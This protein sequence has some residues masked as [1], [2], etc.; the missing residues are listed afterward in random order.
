MNYIS[1]LS[2]AG[3]DPSGGA[4]IQ[5]DLKTISALGCYAATAITAITVQNTKGVEAVHSVEEKLVEQQI[6]AVMDDIHP[7]VVKVG[8]LCNAAIVHAV[9][10]T[11]TDYKHMISHIVI[12]PVLASTSGMSLLDGQAISV[13]KDELI[14]MATLL[15]PNLPET[16]LLSDHNLGAA[17]TE[18]QLHLACKAIVQGTQ[19]NILIKGGHFE[20]SEKTDRLY[21][22][23]GRLVAMFMAHTIK[24]HNTH[25]TGCTLSSAISA[26][27]ARGL[28]LTDA[29]KE[30]KY[31]LTDALQ[32]GA[33]IDFYP[34]N[35]SLN[36]FFDPIPMQKT[37]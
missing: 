36:H 18:E 9:A 20:S 17:P 6:R 14:P 34:G 8:M 1:V 15:T 29:V 25:G 5:A 3:S 32:S 33:D 28:A 4:G 22:N 7:K 23:E 11:L 19:C 16:E 30:A 13:F 12:D 35:G 37:N 26:L 10:K 2:I 24:T 21:D 31:W 27:L